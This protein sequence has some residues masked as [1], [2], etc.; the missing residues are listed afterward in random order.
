MRRRKYISIDNA[1]AGQITAEQIFVETSTG[2]DTILIRENTQLTETAIGRLKLNNIAK[3]CIF[4][5]EDEEEDEKADEAA[6]PDEMPSV[7]TIPEKLREEAISGIHNLFSMAAGSNNV[8]TAYQV[9]KELD[10][11]LDQLIDTVSMES[12]SLV[13]INNLKSHDEYTYHHSLSV[14]VLSIAIGQELG[15]ATGELRDIGRAAI[16]H[17]IGKVMSPLEI[18][19]KTSRLTPGEF[20]VMKCHASDGARYLQEQSIGDESLWRVVMCH[21]EKFDGTGYPLGLAGTDIPLYSRIISVADVYDALTSYRSYRSPMPPSVALEVIMADVGRMFDFNIVEAFTRKVELYPINAT[22]DLS[23]NRSGVVV[24]NK[25]SMRPVLR[26]VDDHELI[27]L[28]SL[29]N[30]TLMIERVHD[31]NNIVEDH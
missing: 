30:L 26:M 31:K 11:I 13:H 18:L 2:I 12:A 16:M 21:H 25:S 24:D 14:A 3:V 23:N 15:I 29:N 9:V 17:D 6:E 20:E 4:A 10:N 5:E 8:V 7:P 27:D 1:E 19:N 28:A 22:V